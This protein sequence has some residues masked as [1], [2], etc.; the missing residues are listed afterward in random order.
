MLAGALI[1]GYLVRVLPAIVVR[2]FVIAAG[3]V[4]TLIYAYRYGF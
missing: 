4:M 2:R 3:T 1:G